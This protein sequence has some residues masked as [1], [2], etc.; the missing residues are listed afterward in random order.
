MICDS[1]CSNCETDN[2]EFMTVDVLKDIAVEN[3]EEFAVLLA[4]SK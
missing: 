1:I 3:T 2:G 4:D